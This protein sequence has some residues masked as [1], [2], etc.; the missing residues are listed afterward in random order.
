MFLC[1]SVGNNRQPDLIAPLNRQHQQSKTMEG[2]ETGIRI[3]FQ[4]QSYR[5]HP[6]LTT[7]HDH[8]GIL[9]RSI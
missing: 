8:T 3:G 1:Y 6:V 5:F 7:V 2:A 9:V 4:R